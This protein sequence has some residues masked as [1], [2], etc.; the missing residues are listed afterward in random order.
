MRIVNRVRPIL[1]AIFA[2]LLAVSVQGRTAIAQPPI[3]QADAGCTEPLLT[4]EARAALPGLAAAPGRLAFVCAGSIWASAPDGSGAVQVTAQPALDWAGVRLF[5]V[6]RD[7]PLSAAERADLAARMDSA[8]QWL[9]D[10][11]LVF[12]SSRDL[13][14]FSAAAGPEAPRPYVG[15]S[16]LHVVD[17][18][19]TAVRRLTSY[20][21]DAGA[22]ASPLAPL[23]PVGCERPDFCFAGL[24]RVAADAASP[25][26]VWIAASVGEIRFSECCAYA[27]LIGLD[28]G[29]PEQVLLTPGEP[30]GGRVRAFGWSPDGGRLVLLNVRGTPPGIGD[31]PALPFFLEIAIFDPETGGETAL[32]RAAPGAALAAVGRPAWSASGLVAFC[33]YADVA[34]A[35]SIYVVASA[36][37][38]PRPLVRLAQPR[39]VEAAEDCAPS[40]SPDGRYLAVGAG[41]GSATLVADLTTGASA[42]VTRGRQAAWSR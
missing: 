29:T 1:P 37:G 2:L 8:P 20:N 10:G 22:Y 32:V 33:G 5:R 36:G 6:P 35:P 27:G 38:E 26:G 28:G 30:P 3:T 42:L 17:A 41:D 21:L 12:S 16:E 40:W 39:S 7:Q 24:V 18:D 15:A 11:R 19:G 9:A 13:L 23:D 14:A 31:G 4:A 34:A 25:D